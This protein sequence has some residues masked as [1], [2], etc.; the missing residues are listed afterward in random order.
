MLK[1]KCV[2]VL[3]ICLL[4]YLFIYLLHLSHFISIFWANNISFSYFSRYDFF[5][6]VADDAGQYRA[7]KIYFELQG[8]HFMMV[9]LLKIMIID[10]F[11]LF[12]LQQQVSGR[13]SQQLKMIQDTFFFIEKLDN[14]FYLQFIRIIAS[15]TDLN[16]FQCTQNYSSKKKSMVE[17]KWFH[18]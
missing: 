12:L 18:C 7:I 4:S 1:T 14:C 10:D 8:D 13:H 17:R 2:S 6:V 11:L 15:Y 5:V 16:H 3:F 9:K